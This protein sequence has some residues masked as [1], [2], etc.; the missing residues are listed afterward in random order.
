MTV[1][2]GHII[3]SLILVTADKNIDGKTIEEITTPALTN[4]DARI[5]QI[6]K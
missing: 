2:Y 3:S 4:I 5:K 6:D 1:Q